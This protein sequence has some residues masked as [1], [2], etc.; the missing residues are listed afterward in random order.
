M[1]RGLATA[2]ASC[3]KHHC[4]VLAAREVGKCALSAE[5]LAFLK[6][7]PSPAEACAAAQAILS[8]G[9]PE[10]AATAI[11]QASLGEVG[12]ANTLCL[13]H[14]MGLSVP[15]KEPAMPNPTTPLPWTYTVGEFSVV[16]RRSEDGFCITTLARA[17]KATRFITTK[18]LGMALE[19]HH[20]Y[21]NDLYADIAAREAAARAV[22]QARKSRAVSNPEEQARHHAAQCEVWA[23]KVQDLKREL[24]AEAACAKE[25]RE[26]VDRLNKKIADKDWSYETLSGLWRGMCER[27]EKRL[28]ENECL[29]RE[30]SVANDTI[31]TLRSE[32]DAARRD[33][34]EWCQVAQQRAK[35]LAQAAAIRRNLL[36]GA[37]FLAGFLGTLAVGVT[38]WHTLGPWIARAWQ[39][40][41]GSSVWLAVVCG[42]VGVLVRRRLP[43]HERP[44]VVEPLV[45]S[46]KDREFCS[47]LASISASLSVTPKAMGVVENPNRATAKSANPDHI[48]PG[49]FACG[50]CHMEQVAYKDAR[51][52]ECIPF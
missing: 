14:N 7:A 47:A 2:L 26:E 33:R 27:S 11:L 34:E 20:E 38:Y 18:S 52:G 39:H 44:F 40:A 23:K 49:F 21:V 30:V 22:A 8:A 4:I 17:G 5:M 46:P 29:N 50:N 41:P 1:N 15:A 43:V 24:A 37:S 28:N 31:A 25:L 16:T 3:S 9:I 10:P 48:A 12:T 32:R 13:L 51:C 45:M 42:L 36:R 19:N 6:M 35:D